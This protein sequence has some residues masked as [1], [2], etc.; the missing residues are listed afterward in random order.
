M[1]TAPAATMSARLSSKLY[2]PSALIL[3]HL[4]AGSAELKEVPRLLMA[5]EQ[6]SE[7]DRRQQYVAAIRKTAS[8][9]ATCHHKTT[10]LA[11]HDSYMVWLDSWSKLSGLGPLVDISV[12]KAPG[13]LGFIVQHVGTSGPVVMLPEMLVGVLLEMVTGSKMTRCLGTVERE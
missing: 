11:A 7:E 2:L 3:T 9:F 6:Y 1:L 13:E 8:L 4:P 12:N 5:N 10:T